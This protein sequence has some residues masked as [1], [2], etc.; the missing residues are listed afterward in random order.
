MSSQSSSSSTAKPKSLDVFN[1]NWTFGVIPEDLQTVFQQM[2]EEHRTRLQ[3]TLTETS[4]CASNNMMM[5]FMVMCRVSMEAILKVASEVH[6]SKPGNSTRSNKI[7]MDEETTAGK[8]LNNSTA[9]KNLMGDHFYQK[10]SN[11]VPM[12]KE[13]YQRGNIAVHSQRL[14]NESNKAQKDQDDN[15]TASMPGTF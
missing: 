3:Q 1:T 2:D 5:T 11:Y 13:M 14:L 15:K 7:V 10:L 6:N 12:A 8:L 9:M 4:R